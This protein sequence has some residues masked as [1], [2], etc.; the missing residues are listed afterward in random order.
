MLDIQQ[1]VVKFLSSHAYCT[2]STIDSESNTPHSA[3]VRYANHNLL[4]YCISA[5]KRK[6]V[7]NI[8]IN[9][10]VSIVVCGRSFLIPP[11]SLIISGEATI[12]ESDDNNAIKAFTSKRLPVS[13]INSQAIRRAEKQSKDIAFIRVEPR[14]IRM[15]EF[16][17]G[18]IR[19]EVLNV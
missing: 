15:N 16:R 13:W 2:I 9:P 1:K 14:M 12:L 5:K 18:F 8:A 6:K 7:R 10:K 11:R 17:N 4:I 3:L 19:S